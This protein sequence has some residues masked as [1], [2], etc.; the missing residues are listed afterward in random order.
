MVFSHGN[1]E[2][3]GVSVFMFWNGFNFKVNDSILHQNGPYIVLDLAVSEQRLTLVSLYGY[4]DDKPEL[5]NEILQKSATFV[6]TMFLFCGDCNI[7]QNKTDYTYNV[8]HDRNRN[9]G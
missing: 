4:N 3:A 6:Y 8:I 2:C 7:V 5:L 1:S 9:P